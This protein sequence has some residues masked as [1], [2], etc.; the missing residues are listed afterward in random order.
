MTEVSQ[1]I[2]EANRNLEQMVGSMNAIN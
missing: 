2:G 1:R